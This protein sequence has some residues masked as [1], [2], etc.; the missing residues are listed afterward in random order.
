MEPAAVVVRYAPHRYI[1]SCVLMGCFCR[2]QERLHEYRCVCKGK[3][4]NAQRMF[5]HTHRLSI[6]FYDRD[7][8]NLELFKLI[9]AKDFSK[10]VNF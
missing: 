6:I 1:M 5:A 3:G 2:G 7:A 4:L 9:K 8:I 10:Y